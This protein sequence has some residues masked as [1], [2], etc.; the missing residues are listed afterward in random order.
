MPHQQKVL[1]KFSVI[2]FFLFYGITSVTTADELIITHAYNLYSGSKSVDF[3]PNGNYIATGDTDGDVGFWKVGDDEAIDYVDLGGEVQCVTFSPDGR[4]LAANGNDGNVIVWLLDVATR[5]TARGTYVHD[6]AGNI[7]SI[8]YSPDGRYIAVG[9]DVRWAYLWDL[10]GGEM[11]GWGKTDASEVYDVAFSPDGR[12]LATG[13]DNGDLTLWELSSWWTDDVNSIDFKPG[14][15]VQSVAFSPDGNYLAADGY[16]GSNTYVNIY[17]MDTRR[18]A[19]QINS[20]D[21]YAIAFSSNGEYIALGDDEATITFYNIGANPTRVAEITA[22]DEVLD[23][24]WSPDGTFNL[25]R[26]RCLERYP[27][28]SRPT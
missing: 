12:Y 1:L 21:V 4:Y 2:V 15:N 20:G 14:G 9:V 11:S 10:N 19:W 17:N 25:G 13:N 8:A 28:D 23:L 26:Q 6:D 3:G 5:T 24:A 22:S 16:D 18:V 27:A 7:N